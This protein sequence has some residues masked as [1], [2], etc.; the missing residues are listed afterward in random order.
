MRLS[1]I[2]CSCSCSCSCS[3]WSVCLVSSSR[4]MCLQGH[5][6]ASFTRM[7]TNDTTVQHDSNN[8]LM[9][10]FS[11][12]FHFN[13]S[14]MCFVCVCVCLRSYDLQRSLTKDLITDV[15]DYLTMSCREHAH[16]IHFISV[17]AIP[18]H[19]SGPMLDQTE[20]KWTWS[21]LG[22][23]TGIHFFKEEN[24]FIGTNLCFVELRSQ[25]R[26]RKMTTGDSTHSRQP[27][28]DTN[29]IIGLAIQILI[30]WNTKTTVHP[31]KYIY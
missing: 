3:C 26:L 28:M 11:M 15:N 8:Q 22:Q 13:T 18:F 25:M 23:A 21:G 19:S 16:S 12:E 6:A 24:K 20:S 27:I 1:F 30:H 7:M 14:L 31:P 17:R 10:T 5:I 2:Y 4:G 29:L 9:I